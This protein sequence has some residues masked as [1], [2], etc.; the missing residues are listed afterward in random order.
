MHAKTM[1]SALRDSLPFFNPRPILAIVFQ[2]PYFVAADFL[3]LN[4]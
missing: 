1:A 2:I 3:E 4:S